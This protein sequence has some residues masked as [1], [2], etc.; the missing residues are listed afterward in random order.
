MTARPLAGLRSSAPVVAVTVA[1]DVD[2]AATVIAGAVA[3]PAPSRDV[4]AAICRGRLA[5]GL[6]KSEGLR[7]NV[8]DGKPHDRHY[9]TR[10]PIITIIT[11]SSGT[12][13]LFAAEGSSELFGKPIFLPPPRFLLPFHFLL[14]SL[15]L[16]SH[17]TAPTMGTRGRQGRRRRQRRGRLRQW[18]R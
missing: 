8:C 3:T 16:S 18:R 5:R 2:V 12:I 14:S 7:K 17:A 9:V 1:V 6:C 13:R 11:Q 4:R 15:A 10:M